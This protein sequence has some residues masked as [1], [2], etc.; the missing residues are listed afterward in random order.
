[1]SVLVRSAWPPTLSARR[2]DR[3][4]KTAMVKHVTTIAK[5]EPIVSVPYQEVNTQASV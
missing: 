5:I 2:G 1:M 3:G 4:T